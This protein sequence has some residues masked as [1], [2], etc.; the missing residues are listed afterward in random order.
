MK[1]YNYDSF[2]EAYEKVKEQI[3]S[4]LKS[5]SKN[6]NKHYF[7]LANN[8]EVFTSPDSTKFEKWWYENVKYRSE[9]GKLKD[10]YLSKEYIVEQ[11]HRKQ[12]SDYFNEFIKSNSITP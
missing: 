9:Y 1:E 11:L 10:L 6:S 3:D 5:I 12:K 8:G 2:W 4:T 7:L